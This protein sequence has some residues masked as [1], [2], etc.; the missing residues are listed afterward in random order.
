MEIVA[1]PNS[2]LTAN[3]STSI[4]PYTAQSSTASIVTS[5]AT[6]NGNDAVLVVDDGDHTGISEDSSWRSSDDDVGDIFPHL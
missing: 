3:P 1:D 4:Q 6:N 5:V 2:P